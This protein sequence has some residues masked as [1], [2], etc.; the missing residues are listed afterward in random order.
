MIIALIFKNSIW[1]S[2]CAPRARAARARNTKTPALGIQHPCGFMVFNIERAPPGKHFLTKSEE[3]N[4]V[5][6]MENRA[7]RFT[8]T[9]LLGSTANI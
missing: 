3:M 7:A 8:I 1:I 5:V 9:L 4:T 2:D 6:F